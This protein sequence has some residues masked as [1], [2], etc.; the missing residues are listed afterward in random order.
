MRNQFDATY[1]QLVRRIMTQGCYKMD[2]TGVGIKS[3]FGY[4]MR[5]DLR[6]GFPLLTTKKVN[7]DAIVYELLWFL[8]G[9]TNIHYLLAHNVNIW[10]D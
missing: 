4:Q 10:T 8:R 7:F 9:D 6:Q 1:C 2:R 5:F 3:I